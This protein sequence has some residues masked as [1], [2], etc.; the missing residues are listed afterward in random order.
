MN[1]YDRHILP[2]LIDCCCG[3][4]AMTE[5]R[6]R[7][8]PRAQGRVLEIGVGSGLN[9]AHY[10]PRKVEVVVG[11]DPTEALLAMA[12]P[13]A[14]AVSFP[15]QL[16]AQSAEQIPLSAQSFDTVVVTFTLC[17]I[18]NLDAA[19]GEMKRLL[20]PEGRLYFSEHGRSPEAHI[21]RWQDRINP[22]WNKIAGGCN[23]NRDIGAAI[24][25]AGFRIDKIDTGYMPKVPLKI[26]GYQYVGIAVPRQD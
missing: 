24:A 25:K 5:Q 9:L 1:F 21:G 23:L 2:R 6:L 15:V 16:L 8:V 22:L 4:E 13:Q 12:E 26:A 3:L 19:L 14:A 18:P 11:V 20:K 7:I 10:D 17:T